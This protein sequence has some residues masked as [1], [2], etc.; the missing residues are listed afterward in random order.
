MRHYDEFPPEW[1]IILF[2]V[3]V[4]LGALAAW[5]YVRFR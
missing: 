2:A 3:G 1:K 4:L 5:V